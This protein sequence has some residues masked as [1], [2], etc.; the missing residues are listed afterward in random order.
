MTGFGGNNFGTGFERLSSAPFTPGMMDKL[1]GANTEF[2]RL[3]SLGNFAAA[4]NNAFARVSSTVS[5]IQG[6]A[7]TRAASSFIPFPNLQSDQHN[8]VDANGAVFFPFPV[9]SL[10]STV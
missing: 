5:N 2:S 7:F 3:A 8:G 4:Q 6:D 1:G 10:F 9:F